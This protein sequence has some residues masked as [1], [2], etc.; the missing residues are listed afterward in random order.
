MV[1]PRTERGRRTRERIVRAAA[2]LFREQGVR[3][4]SVDDVLA[5]SECGKSQLYHYFTGKAAVVEA[6]L[7]LQL[8]RFLDGQRPLMAELGTWSG[9]R[10]WL[11]RLPEEF[12]AGGSVAACP[13][14]ALA[15]ELAGTD[16]HA[17]R[18]LA[19]AFDRWAGEV[20]MGLAALRERGHL[21]PEADPLRLART[22]IAALQGGLLL[23]R[24]YG[25]PAPIGDALDA[26]YARLRVHAMNCTE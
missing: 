15:A 9:V 19:A 4:T 5:R 11:D 14:G 2:E 23:A 12:T 26:A 24:T 22:V 1:E 20:A 3:A 18:A 21:S 16:E 8:G 17:R 10:R 7:D 6:V 25:D 13:I